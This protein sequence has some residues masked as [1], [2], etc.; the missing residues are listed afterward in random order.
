MQSSWTRNI[1]FCIAFLLGLV[2]SNMLLAQSPD[3][4]QR[5][6]RTIAQLQAELEAMKAQ[7]ANQLP[8][9]V[10]YEQPARDSV[11]QLNPPASFEVAPGYDSRI[12]PGEN[13]LLDESALQLPNQTTTIVPES[14]IYPNAADAIPALGNS[15]MSPQNGQIIAPD[16]NPQLPQHVSPLPPVPQPQF[17]QP[18][19]PSSR[20]PYDRNYPCPGRRTLET[21]EV[22]RIPVVR[23]REWDYFDEDRASR[24]RDW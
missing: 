17:V 12:A 20:S 13:I 6:E 23:V 11:T 15:P 4:I 5:M 8:P 16:F 14:S 21:I 22:Y 1:T 18:L 24:F 10:I 7:Q 19:L 3:D 9:S 2:L